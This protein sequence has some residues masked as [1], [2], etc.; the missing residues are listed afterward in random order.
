MHAVTPGRRLGGTAALFA[1]ALVCLVV[2]SLTHDVWPLFVAWI[3]LA[4][5]PWLLTRP[6]A[7]REPA[8]VGAPAEERTAGEEDGT[9]LPAGQGPEPDHGPMTAGPTPSDTGER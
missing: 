8:I 4:A 2:A 9:G 1:V 5:V 6:E 7:G 3:P